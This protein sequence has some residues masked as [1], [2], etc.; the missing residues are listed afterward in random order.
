MSTHRY[1][2]GIQRRD[3]LK[4][5]ALGAAG[6]TLSSYL[7]LAYA[8]KVDPKARAKSA[9]FI[10]L[11]G[12]PTHMDTFD[13]HPDAPSE[14]R[15]EF[16]PIDTNAPGVQICEHLPKLAKCADKFTI[17]RGVSH[18]LAAH[19]LGTKY[20]NTGNRP[21][22]SLEFPGYGAV[23]AK[24]MPGE[25]D[26]PPF[27]AIP[28]SRQVPG[29]LGVKYAGLSTNATPQAGR[30]FTVRGVSLSGGV[31]LE[32][33]EK[34]HKLLKELD[35]TFKGFEESSELVEGLDQF[36]QQAHNMISSPRARKAFDIQQEAKEVAEQF[37]TSAFGQSCLLAVR[38]SM[39]ACGSPPSRTAAGT[40]TRTISID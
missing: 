6:L 4:V 36:A 14:Y 3:F 34:R 30:P 33:V 12:G 13:L 17:L 37:G 16:N 5:G 2:D 10:N 28:N 23:I 22:P 1:C 15:G 29:Y 25:P 40:R 7:K 39:P 11:G 8:G 32:Q 27:V 21:L 19:E 38:R 31:T 26:L 18:T 35:A 24:E 9:I 20:M